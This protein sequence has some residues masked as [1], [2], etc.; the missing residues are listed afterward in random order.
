MR[1]RDDDQT[2]AR[3]WLEQEKMI[4]RVARRSY[5]HNMYI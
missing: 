1:R 4:K 2:R 5:L 3:N